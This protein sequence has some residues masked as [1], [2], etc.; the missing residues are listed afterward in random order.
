MV[1]SD[2]PL[3][4]TVIRAI[5]AFDKLESRQILLDIALDY[6]HNETRLLL[7]IYLNETTDCLKE[8]GSHLKAIKAS[9]RAS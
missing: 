1:A 7:H 5:D 8:L 3:I 6:N 4:Q 2:E 9:V